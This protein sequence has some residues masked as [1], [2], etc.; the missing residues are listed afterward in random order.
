MLPL[1]AH[2]CV[3]SVTGDGDDML[4]LRSK[5]LPPPSVRFQ[6]MAPFD[7]STAHNM[8]VS[9]SATFR[10]MWPSQTIGVAALR[11]GMRSFQAMFVR[12]SHLRGRSFSLLTPFDCG[13][14]HCGQLSA[15]SDTADHKG[16]PNRK[17]KTHDLPV[18][19]TLAVRDVN[20][21]TRSSAPAAVRTTIQR[22]WR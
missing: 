18:A 9:P 20:A 3:P 7:R 11:L 22:V 6:R 2:T 8:I 12:V 4:C 14:R 17:T 19:R 15:E 1:M 16:P 21:I 13:P 5:R 10:K